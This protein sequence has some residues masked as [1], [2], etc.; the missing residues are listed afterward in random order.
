MFMHPEAP[1]KSEL[2]HKSE[3]MLIIHS[4]EIFTYVTFT[5]MAPVSWKSSQSLG[6]QAQW[7][8][9]DPKLTGWA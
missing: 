9:M 2:H 8:L 7:G 5:C 6:P 4:S 3:L 1:K